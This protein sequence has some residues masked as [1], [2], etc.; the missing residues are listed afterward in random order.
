MEDVRCAFTNQ[1]ARGCGG[2]ASANKM[3]NALRAPSRG[4]FKLSVKTGDAWYAGDEARQ[5]AAAV[6]SY[7]TPTGG[8]SKHIGFSKGPRL[9]GMQWTSQNEPGQKA[10]YVATF[11]NGSPTE[12]MYFLANV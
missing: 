12:E 5:L 10:H 3:T 11:D 7:Q 6:L 8:W 2:G 9:P 1:R 4:D